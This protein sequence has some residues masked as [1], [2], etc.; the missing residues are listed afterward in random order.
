M[1]LQTLGWQ[2]FFASHF[3]HYHQQGLHAARVA[4]QYNH[5]Y[6]VYAEDGEL[7]AETTGKLRYQVSTSEELPTTGDWVAI[8]PL[9]KESKAIIHAVLP[10][11]TK[12]SRQAAGRVTQEQVV[13]ANIDTVFLVCGLDQDLNVR[14]LERYLFTVWQNGSS[15]VIVLN[16]ADLSSDVAD[17]RAQVESVAMGLP[18][19]VTSAC[20][21]DGAVGL[22]KYLTPGKTAAFIGSSG[23]GKSSLINRLLG[24][25]RQQIRQLSDD[26]GRGQHTTT[27]RELLLLPGGG[28]IIDTPG[29]REI[30][31]FGDEDTLELAFDDIDSLAQQCRF[32]N[33]QHLQETGCA[34]QQA[35]ADGV[36]E[37][38]RL[39][40]YRKL[41]RELQHANARND[42]KAQLLEKQRWRKISKQ[43]RH[44]KKGMC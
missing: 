44:Y 27:A 40:S 19:V 9:P 43:A 16:K 6:L 3:T 11:K 7:R 24:Y 12:F 42:V 41:Q 25:D 38:Q 1:Q 14:R 5:S 36:L 20:Q 33:C 35:I 22:C 32:R 31:L 8:Q 37:A 30:Q 4:V 21:Q 26:T 34:V 13:A 15:A 39:A 2:D 28:L 18:V 17:Q 10:R 29:M 23:V